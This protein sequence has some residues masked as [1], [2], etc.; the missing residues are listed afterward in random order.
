MKLPKREVTDPK[1]LRFINSKKIVSVLLLNFR[2]MSITT[3]SD[4]LYNMVMKNR[5][6]N[7][8]GL[9]FNQIFYPVDFS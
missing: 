5:I 3:F 1:L 9:F 2:V 4:W 8:D 6:D 7:V